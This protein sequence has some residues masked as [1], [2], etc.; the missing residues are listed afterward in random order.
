MDTSVA[1]S[2]FERNAALAEKCFGSIRA[3]EP[4]KKSCFRL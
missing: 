4:E 2:S 1:K 3:N